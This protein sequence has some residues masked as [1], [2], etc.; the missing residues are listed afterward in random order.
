MK[1][2]TILVWKKEVYSKSHKSKEIYY[3]FKTT[4]GYFNHKVFIMGNFKVVCPIK[5]ITKQK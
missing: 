1:K 4:L 3:E 5:N 2:E